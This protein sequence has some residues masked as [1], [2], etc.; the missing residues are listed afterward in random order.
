MNNN[1]LIMTALNGQITQGGKTVP[2]AYMNYKGESQTYITFREIDKTPQFEA[3][4]ECE[5]SVAKFTIDIFS[6]S[7][8]LD[9]VRQV[10]E[11][12][13]ANGCSWYEDSPDLYEEDTKYYHKALTFEIIN[14]K[15]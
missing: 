12:M 11:K 13:K 4:N 8:L 14:Y 10:K 5:Y 15:E 3:D 1:E 6:K 7:N 9:I 2:I